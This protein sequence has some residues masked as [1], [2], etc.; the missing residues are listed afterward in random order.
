MYWTTES[1]TAELNYRAEVLRGR[2]PR[3]HSGDTARSRP[4]TGRRDWSRSR[5]RQ[6]RHGV[7]A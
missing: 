4:D 5:P 1:F 7:A 6:L 3:R 2:R